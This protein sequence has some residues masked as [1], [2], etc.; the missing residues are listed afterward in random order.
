MN[1]ASLFTTAFVAEKAATVAAVMLS[2]A[3]SQLSRKNYANL[4]SGAFAAE[5]AATI[6]AVMLSHS[7][8]EGHLR[9]V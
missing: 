2:K 5:D 3:S 4:F 9:A 8:K 6:A 7:K 1:Y